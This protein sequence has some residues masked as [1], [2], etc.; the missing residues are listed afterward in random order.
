MGFVLATDLWVET[1]AP[2]AWPWID[3]TEAELTH[4]GEHKTNKKQI[5][6]NLYDLGMGFYC[7]AT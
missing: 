1:P 5:F 2:W 7:G 4:G 3:G 6:M